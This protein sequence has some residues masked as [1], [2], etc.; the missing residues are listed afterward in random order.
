MQDNIFKFGTLIYNE[1][2]INFDIPYSLQIENL[3]E[4]LL[5]VD[6]AGKYLLDL[7]WYPESDPDGEFVILLLQDNN[8]SMP[9]FCARCTT[10]SMLKTCIQKA[11][12]M[13]NG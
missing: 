8:W 4:D 6:F 13:V 9:I 3:N 5:Q 11:V 1:F 7:G 10:P 2:H 12:D